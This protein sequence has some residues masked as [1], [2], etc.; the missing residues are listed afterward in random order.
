[1][2]SLAPIET[3]RATLR[4]VVVEDLEG[5]HAVLGDSATSGGRSFFQSDRESTA[6]WIARR[7]NDQQVHGFSMWC[8]EDRISKEVV[9]LAGLLPADHDE[10]EIGYVIR[11]DHQGAGLA[12]EVVAAIV[13]LADHEGLQLVAT[14]RSGNARSLQVANRCG[15]APAGSIDDE[16]GELLVFRRPTR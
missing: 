14:I 3:N 10:V 9:G 6:K 8:V 12:S 16:H 5:V 1:M 2:T 4:E 7:M 13:D 11:S 15:F